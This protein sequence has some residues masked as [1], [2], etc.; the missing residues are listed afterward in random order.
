MEKEQII[1]ELTRTIQTE[2]DSISD[3]I[4]SLD[5]EKLSKVVELIGSCNG[6]I[7]ISG[8]GTSA[9]AGRKIAHSLSC[10]ECPAV[11]LIP[12]D[13]AHGAL[14][15]LQQ[16]DILILVS[17]GGGTQELVNLIPACKTKGAYLITVT[18]NEDSILGQ[19]A[20][21]CLR[22]KVKAEPCRFNMLATAST[23]AVISAFDAVCIALM[24]YTGYTKEQFAVIHPGGAVGDRLL[25]RTEERTI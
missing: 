18:E 24:S 13:A 6:R 12:S 7:L 10:I 15:S 4:S 20:D 1:N 17:K 21:L 9:M 2:A 11:F 3:L 23:L 16:E 19:S 14:G 5:M 8:C 25:G 22:V